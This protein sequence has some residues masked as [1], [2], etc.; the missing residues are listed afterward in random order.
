MPKIIN[1]HK[2]LLS[3]ISNSKLTLVDFFADWCGPCRIQGPIIDE[4]EKE[5][6][7]VNFLKVNV[8]QNQESAQVYSIRS[9]PSL[10]LFKDG[11]I[12][13]QKPGFQ[14]KGQLI[15]WIKAHK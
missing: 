8:D 12:L 6:S 10:I 5:I 15:S 1:N 3:E 9:I 4:L 14:S 2:N 11:K 13:S 7:D